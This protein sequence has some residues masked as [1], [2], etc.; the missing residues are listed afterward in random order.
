ME[1]GVD[2]EVLREF[3]LQ[4]SLRAGAIS[5]AIAEHPEELREGLH[6]GSPVIQKPMEEDAQ[7]PHL[8]LLPRLSPFLRF[9]ESLRRVREAEERQTQNPGRR[10][11]L[12]AHLAMS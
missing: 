4:V 1:R 10:R 5:L 11:E 6:L 2:M 12:L 7:E 8:T 9:P 3:P